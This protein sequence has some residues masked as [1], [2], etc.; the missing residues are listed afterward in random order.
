MNIKQRL[1]ALFIAPK[2]RDEDV[3]NRELVLNVLLASTL[4]MLSLGLILLLVDWT[5][6]RF[7]SAGSRLPALV[8][9]TSGVGAL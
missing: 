2:Q 5:I 3:R 7:T 9:A 8:I 4:L 6:L 1:Y